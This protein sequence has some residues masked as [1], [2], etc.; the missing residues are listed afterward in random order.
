MLFLLFR[1]R[2][3][4]EKHWTKNFWM[5]SI[6]K[7]LKQV[8][9]KRKLVSCYSRKISITGIKFVM[10]C[11][12]CNTVRTVLARG[13]VTLDTKDMTVTDQEFTFCWDDCS[14]LLL[15]DLHRTSEK[16]KK[17]CMCTMTSWWSMLPTLYFLVQQCFLFSMVSLY[18][19]S[20]HTTWNKL[21]LNIKLLISRS[22]F[23]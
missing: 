2:A 12:Y 16:E 14:D 1:L 15:S 18:K 19:C 8:Q 20:G 10:L 9:T 17:T 22:V 11:H 4:L 21:V 3:L 5:F 6:R 13:L 7:K 23:L